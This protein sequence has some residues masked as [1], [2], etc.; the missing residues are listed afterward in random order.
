MTQETDRTY[1]TKR[2]RQS[3]TA[4]ETADY[5]G[6]SHIHTTMAVAYD[7]LAENATETQAP[8]D[9]PSTVEAV[10]GEVR[11]RGFERQVVSFTPDA[12]R[13]T[14]DSLLRGAN[15]AANQSSEAIP[16]TAIPEA[17]TSSSGSVEAATGG[18]VVTTPE[19]RKPYKVI[20]EHDGGPDTEEPVATVK[21]GEDLIKQEMPTPPER[22]KTR[23]TPPSAAQKALG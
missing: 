11:V 22:D 7:S 12:A 15:E 14:S 5:A 17:E 19:E 6:S 8:R 9:L 10:D 3:R 2:A 23:D 4:A 13:L 1:F 21:E 20:L 16:S 18:R